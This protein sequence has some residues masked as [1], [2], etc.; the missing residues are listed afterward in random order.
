MRKRVLPVLV[1]VGAAMAVTVWQQD[2]SA[3]D[4]LYVTNLEQLAAEAFSGEH[5]YYF[6]FLPLPWQ[7]YSID[8]GEPWWVDCTQIDCTNLLV[9]P[10]NLDSGVTAY[11]V[12]LAKN[13]LTGDTTI[14]PA[15][16][17][18]VVATVAPP[19]GYEPGA[20]SDASAWE[21]WQ[22]LTNC[23]YCYG[24]EAPVP[25]PTLMLQALLADANDYATY[26][27][28]ESNLE[29]EAYQAAQ[30][31][32]VSMVGGFSPMDDGDG[33]DGDDGGDDPCTLTNLL[34]V[35]SVTNITQTANGISITFQSCQ[36]F[37]YLIWEANVLTT[38]TQWL[39]V[40]YVWGQTNHSWTTWIDTATTD[41]D[42]N[43]VTARFY[44]VQRLLGSP[45]AAG[46]DFSMIVSS[47]GSLWTWGSDSSSDLGDGQYTNVF[48]PEEVSSNGC[49]PESINAAQ[50]VAAGLDYGI[51]VDAAGVVW[52]WGDGSQGGLGNGA[53]TNVITPTP[54]GMSNVA[55]VAAGS[56]VT[57]ALCSTGTVF[58]WGNDA[59]GFD[60]LSSGALGAGSFPMD[61]TTNLPVQ[62]LV[63]TGTLIVAIAAGSDG[64]G[65]ALDTT[66]RIWG[67]GNN[68]YGEIGTNVPTGTGAGT[69]APVLVPGISNVIAVAAGGD[70][71][72]ALTADKRVWTLGSDLNGQLGRAANSGANPIPGPVP[73]LSNV[74]AI[75]AGYDFTLAVTSNGL[76]YGWGDTYFGALGTNGPSQITSATV[77]AGISN[78]VQV[79]ASFS[80]NEESY[81]ALA[82]TLND[83]TNQYFAWG[84]DD[85]G[86]IGNGTNVEAVY[87]PYGPLP[88]IYYNA[89]AACIQLG[90]NGSFK[91]QATGT[92]FL[93]F[94]D[95]HGLFGDNALGFTVTITNVV[96]GLFVP[97]TSES[98]VLAGSVSN[99]VIYYYVAS[100]IASNCNS[101]GCA[102]NASGVSTITEEPVGCPPYMSEFIC[103][104]LQCY[105][106][107]GKIE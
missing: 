43:T 34:Q 88:F 68:E 73:G 71:T 47:N 96:S 40:A 30:A 7:A 53:Y 12:V 99:G 10:T 37:R 91:A 16:S 79:G 66:G 60:D 76:V 94:N 22:Q 14:Q 57:L 1:L 102:E 54:I 42:G 63:P 23:P 25:P 72:V 100:G 62:S 36:F 69:N 67:W 11:G 2:A 38:D 90:T 87:T 82:A 33:G 5:C 49:N 70:H 26:A 64:F 21:F 98:G 104:S 19:S 35:F 56:G 77:I 13:I 28:Y 106:L 27:A 31:A 8:G 85:N 24:I 93:Y 65:L 58:A 103:P 80:D 4:G 92:L 78:V 95:Q 48:T 107:V 39:P 17:T 74:V 46:A 52:G 3:Q 105:S 20:S 15:G 41:G 61:F 18:D 83:G 6:P 89:C 32:T 50:S 51:A 29:A 55:T 84:N 59:F 101:G 81:F 86:Q 9:S 45:L 75:S 97:A 44:R